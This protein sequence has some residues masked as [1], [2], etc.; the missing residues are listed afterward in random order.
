[1]VG[2]LLS[3]IFAGAAYVIL[4]SGLISLK[5][6]CDEFNQN[7]ALIKSILRNRVQYRAFVKP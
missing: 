7:T 3:G 4:R 2:L 6:S 1:M 5:R